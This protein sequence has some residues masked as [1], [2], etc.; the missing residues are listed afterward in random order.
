M[1]TFFADA[2]EE[3]PLQAAKT[4]WDLL[5]AENRWR[6]VKSRQRADEAFDRKKIMAAVRASCRD[7]NLDD[8]VISRLVLP[9][10]IEKLRSS[11]RKINKLVTT[12]DIDNAVSHS[13]AHLERDTSHFVDL[14][15]LLSAWRKR[16]DKTGRHVRRKSTRVKP[17]QSIA[18]SVPVTCG[19][20]SHGTIW[21]RTTIQALKDIPS[22]DARRIF[23]RISAISGITKIT[24]GSFG[25]K[26][27]RASCQA[28][29]VISKTPRV[30][31]GVLYDQGKKGTSQIFQ[32]WAQFD[33]DKEDVVARIESVLRENEQ[34]AGR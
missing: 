30:I 22:Q 27:T 16:K 11:D 29:V 21:G 14:R 17:N 33:R 9:P 19:G 2:I 34:W 6:V 31:E 5:R 4:L 7:A 1:L 28:S 13:L 8:I 10:V 15:G 3:N 24:L 26:N 20:K 12:T 25:R 32:V 18:G 23:E